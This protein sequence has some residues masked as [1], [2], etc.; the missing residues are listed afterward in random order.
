[1]CSRP[2]CPN[3]VR[4]DCAKWLADVE[5]L[6]PT[7]VVRAVDSTGSDVVGARVFVDGEPQEA[8]LEGKEL[9]VDPGTHTLRV[10]RDGSVPVE[11]RIVVRESER[12]RMVSVAF[13]AAVVQPAVASAA[14]PGPSGE[15]PATS[16]PR[17]LVLP[18]TLVVGGGV[19]LAVASYLWAAGLSEHS[20]MA[21]GCATT[22]TCSQSAIDSS[23]GK[24]LAGDVVGGV[25]IV[26]AAVGVG[27]IVFGGSGAPQTTPV[28]LEPLAGGG[29]LRMKGSF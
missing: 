3:L 19:T 26:A 18:I 14:T 12:H 20:T 23:R 2:E 22:H 5:A 9:E 13:A 6:T 15:S 7:I 1:M 24:L 10:E 17:S 11:Q 21:S 8:R 29:L 27:L 4:S 25:G 28:A 16:S